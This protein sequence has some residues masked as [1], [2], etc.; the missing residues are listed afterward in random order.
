SRR[1]DIEEVRAGANWQSGLQK[2]R[3]IVCDGKFKDG[4]VPGLIGAL[5]GTLTASSS[6]ILVAIATPIA[7]YMAKVG[8]EAFCKAPQSTSEDKENP[9]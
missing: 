1:A 9:S 7:I 2:A 6:P 3:E 5:I 8:M 4:L